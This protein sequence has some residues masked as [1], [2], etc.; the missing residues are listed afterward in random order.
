MKFSPGI[1]SLFILFAPLFGYA[2]LPVIQQQFKVI[3]G[4]ENIKFVNSRQVYQEGNNN[5]SFP[6]FNESNVPLLIQAW[7]EDIDLKTGQLKENEL[8]KV[9]NPFIITPPLTKIEASTKQEFRIVAADGEKSLPQD[10]ESVYF[11]AIKSI[12]PS[13]NKSQDIELKLI[14]T[15]YMKLFYRPKKLKDINVENIEEDL[16]IEFSDDSIIFKNNSPL[17]LTFSMMSIN[18]RSVAEKQLDGM[19]PPFSQQQ[20]SNGL[21]PKIVEW[22]FITEY[23]FSSN[24]TERKL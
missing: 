1:F 24:V 17:H 13:N 18:G 9:N 16:E 22:A 11:I 5:Q 21:K 7:V 8:G 14:P 2:E 23:G 20:Y 10:R 3:D 19:L 4:A 6:L 12:S 15:I